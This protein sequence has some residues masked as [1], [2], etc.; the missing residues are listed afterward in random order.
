MSLMHKHVEC[1]NAAIESSHAAVSTKK[2][3]N[4][5]VWFGLLSVKNEV[6]K[7]CWIIIQSTKKHCLSKS[8]TGAATQYSQGWFS[9]GAM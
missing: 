8:L 7:S 9:G 5:G 2:E 3:L 6:S 1:C 4:S